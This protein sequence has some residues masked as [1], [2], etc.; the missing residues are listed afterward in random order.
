M[1][2]QELKN[3]LKKKAN[4][5]LSPFHKRR[6]GFRLELV[7]ACSEMEGPLAVEIEINRIVVFRYFPEGTGR[8]HE[9]WLERKRNTVNTV[10]KSTL[11]VFYELQNASEDIE[12]DWLL[13]KTD[14]ADCGGAFPIRLIDGCLIGSIA[15]SGL[16]HLRD[17]YA[18]IS[19]IERYWEK[20]RS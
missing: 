12:N 19:G 15:V 20:Y 10:N 1:Y 5:N 2:E 8:F 6:M 17:H 4:I 11:R 9:M 18:L 7:A 3:V 16:P 14:Y 13:P